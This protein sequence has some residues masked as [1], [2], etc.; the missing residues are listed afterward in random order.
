MKKNKKIT[1]VDL[2]CGAGGLTYGLKKSGIFVAAGY[3][4]DPACRFAFE[5]N[6]KAKF[7]LKRIETL[8]A[9]EVS[10]YFK[11]SKYTLLA[12][13]APCQPFSLL[14]L[15]KSDESDNR[16]N[17][18]K[19]FQKLAVRLRPTFI[20]MENVPRL[21]KQ[22]NFRCFKKALKNAGYYI[23][24]QVVNC[25]D[26][27][28]PQTRERLV[29]LASK[30]APIKLL[31]PTHKKRLKTVH[32]CIGKL[33]R[34]DAGSSCPSD[35]LHCSAGLSSKN[36]QRIQASLPG[37]SWRDWP[38]KLVAKCHKQKTGKTYPSVY[39][40]MKWNEPAPTITTQFHGFGNGR[41]GHPNQNRAISLREGAILQG[42]P[43]SYKFMPQDKAI[44]FRTIGRLVGN[45]VP[46]RLAE[47][48]GKS[49]LFH[50]SRIRQTSA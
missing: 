44:E 32:Q 35:R 30:L 29:L 1:A 10:R 11:D 48:I 4:S 47:I 26:Y 24:E 39:G 50:L 38:K 15:G 27:G 28:V 8:Q 43:K 7:I 42:F 22:K 20:T 25:I 31:P 41:F 17:L 2:F 40:R 34:L 46:T 13:C 33:P 19:Y 36:L 23:S 9:K 16:W 5:K 6:N 49:F 45:S 14:R 37:G 12:G 18:L 21:Q 3:D